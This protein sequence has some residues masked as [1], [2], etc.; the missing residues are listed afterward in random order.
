MYTFLNKEIHMSIK[1]LFFRFT[2]VY[3]LVMAVAGVVAGTLEMENPSTLNT[4]ILIAI[5][6]WCFY[7]YSIK[8]KRIISAKAKWIIIWLLLAGDL[9]VSIILATPMVILTDLSISALAIGMGIV[10]PLHLL[11]F[12]AFEYMV[13]KQLLKS[14]AFAEVS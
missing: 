6:Y 10:L 4:P 3:L 8:N 5:T 11:L 1:A 12:I 9:L 7:S 2:I 14:N 13:R